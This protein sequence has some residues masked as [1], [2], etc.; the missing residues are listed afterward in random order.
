MVANGAGNRNAFRNDDPSLQLALQ[1][2]L[3]F[4]GNTR[5]CACRIITTHDERHN[6]LQRFCRAARRGL[7]LQEAWDCGKKPGTRR[8]ITKDDFYGQKT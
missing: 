7:E 8:P 3:P 2:L 4:G 1:K 5:F 6:K